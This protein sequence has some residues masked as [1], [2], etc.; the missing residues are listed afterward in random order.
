MYIHVYI[1]I[2]FLYLFIY[3]HI[4]G[5]PVPWVSH[6]FVMFHVHA[7][8]SPIRPIDDYVLIG[9]KVSQINAIPSLTT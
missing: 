5:I 2:Y 7:G 3:I 9:L 4:L 1:Y 8:R 6:T